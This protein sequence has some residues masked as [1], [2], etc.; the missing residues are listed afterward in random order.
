MNGKPDALVVFRSVGTESEAKVIQALLA[1]AGIPAVV[2]GGMLM[3]EW[4]VSQRALGSL[5]VEVKIPASAVDEA[6]SII[7]QARAAGA[8]MGEDE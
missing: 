7:V 6:E 2:E 1:G 3:D 5:G 4:A 8:E